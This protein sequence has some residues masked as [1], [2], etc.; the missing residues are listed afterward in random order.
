MKYITY[1]KR[2][3]KLT[4]VKKIKRP[5]LEAMSLSYKERTR[6]FIVNTLYKESNYFDAKWVFPHRRFQE[7][8]SGTAFI[9]EPTVSDF[10]RLSAANLANFFH[11]GGGTGR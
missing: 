3:R 6:A 7:N 2:I 4:R 1:I 11:R 9:T 10:S 8:A 5:F